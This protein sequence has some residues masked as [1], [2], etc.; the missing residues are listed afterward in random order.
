MRLAVALM[1]LLLAGCAGN[2]AGRDKA[3][4]EPD[5]FQVRQAAASSY[6]SKD[7]A[8]SEKQYTLLVQKVP[9]E[10]ENWFRLGN[11]YA[12]TNRP[13]QAI[14]A[15]REALVRAP[16]NSKAWFNM[17]ILQL[18]TAA[19]SLT[20][21]QRNAPDGDPLAARSK[22]VV[23]QILNIIKGGSEAGAAEA[24]AAGN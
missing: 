24:G 2:P 8:E 16:D 17:A 21:L 18:N 5:L 3:A 4:A 12:R 7:Y 11:I 13:E 15:Y 23:T 20:E 14:A 9:V 10:A 1:I 22:E 19:S 6:A